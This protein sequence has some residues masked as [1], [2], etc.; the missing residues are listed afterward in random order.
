[1]PFKNLIKKFKMKF[2]SSSYSSSFKVYGFD[3]G[4]SHLTD[5]K[6]QDFLINNESVWILGRKY[7]TINEFKD[8]QDDFR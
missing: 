8:L 6:L 3:S 4:L 2:F 5:N 1:M 7:S